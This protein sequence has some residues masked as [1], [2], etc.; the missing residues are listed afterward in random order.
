MSTEI[1]TLQEQIVKWAVVIDPTTDLTSVPDDIYPFNGLPKGCEALIGG[2]QWVIVID[3]QQVAWAGQ[4]GVAC[5]MYAE[6]LRIRREHV[7]RNLANEL[8]AWWTVRKADFT[9]SVD[10]ATNK[11][12]YEDAH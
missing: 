8:G 12:S 11:V 6:A 10:R 1:L 9:M 5:L 2:D 7:Q 3:E 4:Y